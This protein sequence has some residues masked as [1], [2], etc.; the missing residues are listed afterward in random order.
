MRSS[1]TWGRLWISVQLVVCHIEKDLSATAA[2]LIGGRCSKSNAP[3]FAASSSPL[4][5]CKAGDSIP[6]II[7]QRRRA[8]FTAVPSR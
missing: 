5:H 8:R 3:P 1:S 7:T 2:R 4:P 6:H